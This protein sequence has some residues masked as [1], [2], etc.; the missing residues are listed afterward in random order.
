MK[1]VAII[2]A[3]MGSTRL[4]G[5]VLKEINNKPLL[6]YQFERLKQTKKIDQLIIAT[7]TNKAD[8]PIIEFCKN[9]NLSYFR[10]SENDVLSR[11]YEAA[12]KY[13]ADTV[14]RLTADCPII[15][16]SVVD[17]IILTFENNEHDYVSNTLKRFYPRG[18]DTEVFAFDALEKAHKN[19]D[20][21]F[22]REHVTPY[23]YLNPK[24]FHLHN[25]EYV[26]DQSAHRWTVDTEEDF[27]LIE[28]ILGHFHAEANT[29]SMEDTLSYI[30]KHPELK[31][32]NA[33]IEQKK[34]G[35]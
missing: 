29:F 18:M 26:T 7:T 1:V 6:E 3:R 8:D 23:I 14:V 12:K 32:I 13:N 9:N 21:P 17:D 28:K 35:L 15:D 31:E 4:P 33:T 2:Q 11:Y 16:P 5:K 19:A 34:L 10:G 30:N 20:K 22:E 27:L 24:I 25:L